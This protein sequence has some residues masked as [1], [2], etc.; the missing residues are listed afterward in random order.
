M[1]RNAHS[2]VANWLPSSPR[3]RKPSAKIDFLSAFEDAKPGIEILRVIG[4]WR[5]GDAQID[6][7]KGC[8]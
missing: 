2:R 6:A 8:T 5:I 3:L 7:R 4:A 1:L